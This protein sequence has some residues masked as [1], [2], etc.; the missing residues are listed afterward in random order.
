MLDDLSL[1]PTDVGAVDDVVVGDGLVTT[2]VVPDE[3]L[4]VEVG[5]FEL[6]LV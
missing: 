5:L 3:L 4:L 1:V 6:E 2:T